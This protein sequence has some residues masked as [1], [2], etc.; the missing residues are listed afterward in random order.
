VR[1]VEEE[2]VKTYTHILEE[3][4]AGR[5]VEG[6]EGSGHHYYHY[7]YSCWY[8]FYYYFYYYCY[9]YYY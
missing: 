3:I 1:C 7:Y 6:W 5:W 2:V 9:Y 4:D 8:Y